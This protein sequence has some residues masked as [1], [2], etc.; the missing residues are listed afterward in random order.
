MPPV[1]R[2]TITETFLDR[3]RTSPDKV[4]YAYKP[5][6]PEAGP[7]D[8]WKEVTF[9]QFHDDC[10]E[11][12]LGLMA[13]GLGKGDRAVILSATRY[14]WSL[15]DMAILGAGGVTGR[16][17]PA[18]EQQRQDADECQSKT[19]HARVLVVFKQTAE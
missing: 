11:A 13:L 9:R 5:T 2:R 6:Y 15:A 12:S 16:G 10:R 7:V 18:A 4:A 19:S 1:V 3:V 14:E 17:R 8:R